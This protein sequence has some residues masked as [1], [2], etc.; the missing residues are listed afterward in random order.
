MVAWLYS[1]RR[2]SANNRWRVNLIILNTPAA[3][4][5]EIHNPLKTSKLRIRDVPQRKTGI[6]DHVAT[7]LATLLTHP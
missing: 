5:K 3:H 7:K 2:N 4:Q 1:A 6:V